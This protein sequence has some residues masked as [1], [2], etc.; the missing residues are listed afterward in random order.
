[1]PEQSSLSSEIGS[2]IGS[3]I[4]SEI[5]RNMLPINRADDLDIL[6]DSVKNKRVVMLGEASHGTEEY[7]RMRRIISQRLIRD[8]AFSFIAV[9]GDW[10]D[11]HRLNNYIKTGAGGNARQ[12]LAQN[13]RWPTWMWANDEIVKLAEWM[14]H[15]GADYFGLDMY[16]LFESIAE[17]VDYMKKSSP[18]LAPEIEKR[19]SCFAPFGKTEIAYARSL[20]KFPAGCGKEVAE[21]LRQLLALRVQ[22]LEKNGDELFSAQQNA[23]IIASAE[24]YYRSMFAADENG[25]NIRDG[26]MMDM[27]DRL[28]E[29]SGEGA[30]AIVWAHNTHIGDYRATDMQQNGYINLGGLARQSYGVENVALVGFGSYQGQVLAS[31]AWDGPEEIMNLPPAKSNSIEDYFHRVAVRKK[32]RQFYLMLN[33]DRS[34][35]LTQ[36]MGHRAV[37][38]VYQPEHE[39]RG[40]YVP[41]ELA[42]R[43]DAFVFI[44][45]TTAL[46]SLHAPFVHGEFPETWPSGL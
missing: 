8:H 19:Y 5:E 28:L 39:A 27:L 21:N 15:E 29:N 7:Y 1:M 45:R 13:N 40:N 42:N 22:D 14:R 38:V 37:G 10:P 44:D 33:R 24:S 36:K 4:A 18:Q 35:L 6:I 25:W 11:A 43:Y 32:A 16:S 23:H 41:T 3:E 2:E 46:S 12:V 31:R 34:K 26:H 30:K 20:I 17:V 9:E